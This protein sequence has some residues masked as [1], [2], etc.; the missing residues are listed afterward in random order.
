MVKR[1]FGDDDNAC[2]GD[3]DG[4]NSNSTT[5]NLFSTTP[6]ASAPDSPTRRQQQ[7]QQRK[8]A[9]DTDADKLLAK[10]MNALSLQ[11]RETLFE[12]IHGVLDEVKETPGLVS[13]ALLFNWKKRS[14]R[15][16]RNHFTIEPSFSIQDSSRTPSFG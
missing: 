8:K 14:P 11:E 3:T 15:L 1:T 10:E 12:D 5:C 6:T 9:A 16:K 7:Q 2:Y 4:K 13:E